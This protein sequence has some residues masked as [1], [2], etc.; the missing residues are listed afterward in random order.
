MVVAHVELPVEVGLL[1][2]CAQSLIPATSCTHIDD[3]VSGL[4]A[5]Q[6]QQVSALPHALLARCP[7]ATGSDVAALFNSQVLVRHRPM[8]GT[9]HITTAQDFHWMRVALKRD[10]SPTDR[11]NYDR[12][13]INVPLI[14]QA[15]TVAWEEIANHGGQIPRAELFDAWVRRLNTTHPAGSPQQRRWCTFLMYATM[16]LGAIVEGPM[17][18][19]QHLFIDAR[20]LPAADSPQSGFALPPARRD[21]GIVEIARRYIL[22]HG[23]VTTGDFAWWA[24]LSKTTATAAITAASEVDPSIGVFDMEPDGLRRASPRSDRAQVYMRTDLRDVAS[25]HR[26]QALGLL[27]LPSFDEIYVGYA[28]RTCLTDNAGDRLICPARNGMFKPLIIYRGRLVA[29]RP[30]DGRIRWLST[31]SK[32]LEKRTDRVVEQTLHRLKA[33]SGHIR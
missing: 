28:N 9:V 11:R 27:F 33:S 17:G 8:R 6:G 5:V 2:I 18:K 3:V 1:R 16:H 19:N 22:G 24:G 10:F 32:K 20:Q 23:P 4:L 15:C 13:G 30:A 31:P 12:L 26:E 25:E 14:D 7:E 29:V 21:E